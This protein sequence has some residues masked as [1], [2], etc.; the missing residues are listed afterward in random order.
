MLGTRAVYHSIQLVQL[1]WDTDVNFSFLFVIFF[2]P[3]FLPSRYLFGVNNWLIVYAQ[4][5]RCA[6]AER[7]ALAVR[8]GGRERA[9]RPERTQGGCGAAAAEGARAA[10]G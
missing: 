6:A 8:E 7:V 5:R 4:A 2:P 10:R 3:V 1:G 9:R